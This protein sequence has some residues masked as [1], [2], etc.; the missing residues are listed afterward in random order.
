MFYGKHTKARV[1]YPLVFPKKKKKK[2]K[3]KRKLLFR[4]P[5]SRS[6]SRV[7]AAFERAK[8]AERSLSLPVS[9]MR[10]RARVISPLFETSSFSLRKSLSLSL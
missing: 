3:K 10:R 8:I 5:L 1:R 6:L 2:K 7:V 4:V 9:C